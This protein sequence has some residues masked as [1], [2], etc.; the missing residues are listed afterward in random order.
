MA[1]RKARKSIAAMVDAY[2]ALAHT[3]I[4]F[5]TVCVGV[6]Q[7]RDGRHDA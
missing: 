4:I 5:P 2:L 3:T 7:E 6:T 1:A